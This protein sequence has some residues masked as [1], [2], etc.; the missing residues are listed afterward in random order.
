MSSKNEYPSVFLSFSSLDM[1]FVNELMAVLKYQKI[2]IWDYSNEIEAIEAGTIIEERLKKEILERSV[3]IPLVSVNS[4]NPA[5]GRYTMMETNFAIKNGKSIIPIILTG[6]PDPSD[7]LY[8]YSD[9]KDLLYLRFDFMDDKDFIR[10]MVLLASKLNTHFQPLDKSHPRLPLWSFFRTE[11]HEIPRS[12]YHYG[13]LMTILWNFNKAF[14][15]QDWTKAEKLI[16]LFIRNCEYLVPEYKMF[17]PYIVHAVCLRYLYKPNEAEVSYY[18]AK[19][20]RPG[21][22]EEN[23]YGG[24]GGVYLERGD[25]EKSY[26]YFEKSMQAAPC[27]LN[28]DEK[29]NYVVA[30]LN[31][32]REVNRELSDFVL[33]LDPEKYV[34]DA[35][36]IYNTKAD[37]LYLNG[38]PFEA[39]S[40]LES[41]MEKGSSDENTILFYIEFLLSIFAKAETGDEKSWDFLQSR[42][43]KGDSGSFYNFLIKKAKDSLDTTLKESL[44]L[45]KTVVE[46]SKRN[47]DFGTARTLFEAYIKGDYNSSEELIEYALLLYHLGF[48][49]D[50]VSQAEQV[51]KMSENMSADLQ[52]DLYFEGFARYFL[53]Q[54]EFAKFCYIRSQLDQFFYDKYFE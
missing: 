28:D 3:F 32:G 31:T 2:D 35:N 12:N 38:Y 20:S 8:P 24:L 25:F 10:N 45:R 43:K 37:L 49:S 41:A 29:F 54:H 36:K 34:S 6:A 13:L 16:D 15:D 23:I 22:G 42:I 9:L 39:V 26:Y 53:G 44:K 27:G 4:V 21:Y 46:L 33:D 18:K 7:W 50:A 14:F 47:G 1:K 30:N 17:Y 48:R 51:V 11:I 19:D 40:M 52:K 5:H